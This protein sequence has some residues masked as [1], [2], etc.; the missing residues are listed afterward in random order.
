MRYPTLCTA[1][2]FN[3]ELKDDRYI[4]VSIARKSPDGFNGPRMDV[5]APSAEL[6][7]A[8]NAMSRHHWEAKYESELARVDWKE[9]WEHVVRLGQEGRKIVAFLCWEDIRDPAQWCHRR[10]FAKRAELN[11]GVCVTEMTG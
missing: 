6:L 7:K 1:R 5:F 10:T 8:S 11:W 3:P 2:F 4:G 9:A